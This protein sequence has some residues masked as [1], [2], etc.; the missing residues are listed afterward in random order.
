MPLSMCFT[1]PTPTNPP[2]KTLKF[3]KE[4]KNKT[5]IHRSTNYLLKLKYVAKIKTFFMAGQCASGDKHL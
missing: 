1:T 2:L 5:I 3:S 4:E